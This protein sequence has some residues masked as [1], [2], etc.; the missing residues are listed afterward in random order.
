MNTIRRIASCL[1]VTLLP[2]GSALAVDRWVSCAEEGQTCRFD[3]VRRV[4]YGAGQKWFY[5]QHQEAVACTSGNFGGDPA[6]GVRKRCRF[7]AVPDPTGWLPTAPQ[8]QKCA[9]QGEIC[10]IDGKRKVVYGHG[11]SWVT[12]TFVQSFECGDGIFGD[13]APSKVKECR[14]LVATSGG[15][16][17]PLPQP[18]PPPGKRRE[19][20][21]GCAIEGKFCGFDGRRRVAFGKGNR[22]NTGVY[23]NG[24]ACNRDNFGD[25][26]PGVVK[27]CRFDAASRP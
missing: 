25:P 17:T 6:P 12:E 27:E 1:A 22:W 26:A 11:N 7:L 18:A 3:G 19:E 16:S 21:V 14:V 23:T 8:W 20:W 2:C 15:M 24:V 4:A 13:P 9:S 5:R 10:R